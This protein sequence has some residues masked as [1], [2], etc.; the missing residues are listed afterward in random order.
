L[1]WELK[2]SSHN[3]Y[4]YDIMFVNDSTGWTVGSSGTILKTNDEGETWNIRYGLFSDNSSIYFIDENTGWIVGDGS[5]AKTTNS[6]ISWDLQLTVPYGWLA[7]IK[8]ID[9]DKGWVV[10]RQGMVFHTTDGG[11]TWELKNIGT[12]HNL[13][14]ICFVDEQ[15]GW[16]SGDN[17]S[18]LATTNGGATFIEE[19]K[20][21]NIPTDYYLSNNYPNPFNPTTTINY[22]IPE[23]NFV[24]IKVYDVLG[25]EVATL[26]NEEKPSGNYEIEFNATGLPSGVY[27]Y[28]LQAGS[29][30]ETKKMVLMK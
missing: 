8:F 17:G 13:I 6:G 29:Y 15:N 30:V 3:Y 4:L 2:N 11:A 23:L 10:G 1:N 5:V 7:S 24:T 14:S 25:N 12:K 28:R 20:F 27:F 16:I 26:I 9:E 18:I 21:N 19:Y 22:H